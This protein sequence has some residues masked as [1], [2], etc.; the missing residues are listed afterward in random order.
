MSFNKGT[1]FS[2]LKNI[3]TIHD[4]KSN[5]LRRVETVAL[6]ENGFVCY[7]DINCNYFQNLRPICADGMNARILET[8]VG[9]IQGIDIERYN[10]TAMAEY[11]IVSII[12]LKTGA[13]LLQ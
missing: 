7:I 1:V 2:T 11:K 12:D 9:T 8:S 5:R 6:L 4:N 10:K 3:S 13:M